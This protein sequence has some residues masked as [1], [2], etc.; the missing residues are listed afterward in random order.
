MAM[1][2]TSELDAVNTILSAVGEPPISSLDAQNGADAAVA[3]N[4]LKET[5][6]EVQSMGWHFNTVREVELIPDAADNN[7]IK[8]TNNT[9][10]VDLEPQ[11]T[12]S[13][14]IVQRGDYIY[15]RKNQTDQFEGATLKAT[16]TYV[17]DWAELPEP[18][19]RLITTRA[20]RIFQGRMV[21]S[22]DHYSFT[23]QDEMNA[24]AL[25]KEFEGDTAG[26]SIFGNYDVYRTVDRGSVIN[27]VSR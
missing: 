5:S 26:H 22:G 25:L 14:D 23:M 27:K 7:R 24:M 1:A 9:V 2:R 17:L 13:Y 15:D 18:A 8:T 6:R 20:A 4:I 16:V 10:R 21:G 19:R 3:H 12:G 11:H